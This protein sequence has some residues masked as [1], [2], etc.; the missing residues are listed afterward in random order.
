MI[1]IK[2]QQIKDLQNGILS[3]AEFAKELA[4]TYPSIEI[5]NSFVEL[6]ATAQNVVEEKPIVIDDEDWQ[7]IRNLFKIRGINPVT[8]LAENRGRKAKD[9]GEKLIKKD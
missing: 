2:N 7:R 9:N 5:A 6:L 4:L 3:Q 8:G 1:K